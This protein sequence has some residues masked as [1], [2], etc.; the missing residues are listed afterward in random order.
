MNNR[1]LSSGN[2]PFFRGGFNLAAAKAV[3]GADS[4][5]LVGAGR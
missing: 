4:A 3:A 5:E 1:K 2:L